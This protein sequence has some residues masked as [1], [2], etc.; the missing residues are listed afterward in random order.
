MKTILAASACA[1]AIVSASA[2]AAVQI[3]EFEPNQPGSDLPTQSVELLGTA[4]ESFSAFLLSIEA[5]DFAGKGTVDRAVELSGTFDA[6]GLFTT[7][8]DDIENPSNTLILLD[9]F[10]GFVGDDLDTDNDGILDDLSGFG[11][12][13]DAVGIVDNASDVSYAGQ[14]GLVDFPFIGSEPVLMFR[15]GNTAEWFAVDFNGE[16]YDVLGDVVTSTFAP[17][18]N[19]PTFGAVNPVQGAAPVPVPAAALLFGSAVLMLRRRAS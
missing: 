17:G 13:L 19:A 2:F 7:T 3:N 6:N 5:D 8:I 15:E 4:G 16:I 1:W 14:F 11:N 12:V 10:T 9:A 18:S